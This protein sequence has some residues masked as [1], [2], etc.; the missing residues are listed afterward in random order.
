MIRLKKGQEYFN[1]VTD[2]EKLLKSG[3]DHLQLMQE[4]YDESSWWHN[5]AALMVVACLSNL[6]DLLGKKAWHKYKYKENE[7][8]A[9]NC[10]RNAY[11]HAG[12][13]LSKLHNKKCL[14]NVNSFL[15]DLKKGEILSRKGSPVNP[16]FKIN[17]TKV[18][19]Y[20]NAIHR[21]RALYLGLLEKAGII[22]N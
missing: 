13:D 16:Y 11:V 14:S 12:S 20:G 4:G 6:E 19:L 7:F 1:F 15:E 3:P 22:V 8:E 2:L 9:L 18:E 17:G 5:L 21:M 10:I